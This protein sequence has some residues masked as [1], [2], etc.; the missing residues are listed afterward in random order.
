MVRN[1]QRKSNRS[2]WCKENFSK[3]ICEKKLS[4]GMAS[5]RYCIPSTTL[6]RH[7]KNKVSRPGQAK[8]GNFVP[9]FSPEIENKLVSYLKEM[10]L[11]FFG[12]TKDAICSL[13]Y[14]YTV[15]N[16]IKN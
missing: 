1:Y 5:K 3:A 10:Q 4:V 2:K 15:T 13:A 12:L 6:I 14:E 11:R 7:L 8:L 9:T 16:N